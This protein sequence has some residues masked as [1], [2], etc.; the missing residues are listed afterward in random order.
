[1]LKTAS[2]K[3]H[4]ATELMLRPA[5]EAAE[6]VRSGRIAVELLCGE[7]PMAGLVIVFVVMILLELEDLRDRLLRL[8]GQ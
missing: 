6:A 1:M 2:A 4:G 5:R 3:C 8:A 7:E